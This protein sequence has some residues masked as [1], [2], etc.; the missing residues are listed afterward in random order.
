M[1]VDAVFFC[2]KMCGAQLVVISEGVYNLSHQTV[3]F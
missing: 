1:I 2:D 3:F